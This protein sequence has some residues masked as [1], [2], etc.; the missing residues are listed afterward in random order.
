MANK[1]KNLP[2]IKISLG[3]EHLSSKLLARVFKE[4][5]EVKIEP[6]PRYF[7]FKREM[8]NLKVV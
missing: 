1:T 8:L 2:H 7:K 3:S 6:L 5:V 4:N